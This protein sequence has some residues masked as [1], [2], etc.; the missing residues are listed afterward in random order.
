M[1]IN[2]EMLKSLPGADCLMQKS[3]YFTTQKRFSS[4]SL[5]YSQDLLLLAIIAVSL[6]HKRKSC[7]LQKLQAA[8][9]EFV[10]GMFSKA[11]S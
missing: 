8:R 4:Q 7:F 3:K 11:N 6:L 1:P 5:C 10:M 9:K 2:R